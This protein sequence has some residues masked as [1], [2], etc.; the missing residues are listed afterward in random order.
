MKNI[1]FY[2]VKIKYNCYHITNN[3]YESMF[4][5]RFYLILA[6]LFIFPLSSFADE[7][8]TFQEMVR[9]ILQTGGEMKEITE[10]LQPNSRLYIYKQLPYMKEKIN[11]GE[12]LMLSIKEKS[13]SEIKNSD[14]QSIIQDMS[15][16]QLLTIN[17]AKEL[18]SIY[19]NTGSISNK[20]YRSVVGKYEREA[21]RLQKSL[22]RYKNM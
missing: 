11:K 5:K 3:I 14:L 16:M 15:S 1:T 8:T 4:M 19:E 21:K 10:T 18:L 6:I 20:D 13:L 9:S 2:I 12:Q 22:E 17:V 7:K